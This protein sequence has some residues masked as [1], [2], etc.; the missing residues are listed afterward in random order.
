MPHTSVNHPGYAEEESEP[1]ESDFYCYRGF[2]SMLEN[3]VISHQI[4]QGYLFSLVQ[5]LAVPPFPRLNQTSC[6]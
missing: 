4:R 1:T 2:L 3:G 5:F 6:C